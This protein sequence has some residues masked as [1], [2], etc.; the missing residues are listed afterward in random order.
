MAKTNAACSSYRRRSLTAPSQ[1]GPFRA[2]LLFFLFL[3]AAAV[4]SSLLTGCQTVN[5][6]NVNDSFLTIRKVVVANLPQGIREESMNGRELTS[7]FFSPKN[8]EEDASEKSTRAYAKV[9]ILNSGRP[10]DLNVTVFTEKREKTSYQAEGLDEDLTQQLIS[11]IK[12]GL[13]DR[14]DDRNIIDD[15]RAF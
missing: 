13:A 8:W 3:G 9:M 12:A 10:Y 5:L 4:F 1:V 11:R 7:G 15:F 14:R 6:P 2:A